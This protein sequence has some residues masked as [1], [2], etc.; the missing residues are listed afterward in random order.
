LLGLRLARPGGQFGGGVEPLGALVLNEAAAHTT[1]LSRAFLAC[2][3]AGEA[4]ESW[5]KL[6]G[7]MARDPA[8]E[9][10][11]KNATRTILAHGATSG[12]AMLEGFLAGLEANPA[13][14]APQSWGEKTYVVQTA[15]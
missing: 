8:D 2:A 3:A 12:A 4:A 15:T 13:P 9:R 6:L 10:A 11:I 14:P 7:L 5:H 1:L